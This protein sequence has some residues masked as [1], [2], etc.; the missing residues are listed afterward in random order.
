VGCD[1]SEIREDWSNRTDQDTGQE[2]LVTKGQE[3]NEM[4]RSD[5]TWC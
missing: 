2:Q 1:K 4:V 3:S 5:N